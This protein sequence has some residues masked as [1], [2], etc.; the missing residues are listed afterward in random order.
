MSDAVSET[1]GTVD[2]CWEFPTTGHIAWQMRSHWALFGAPNESGISS[3]NH[4][5]EAL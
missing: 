1:D 5:G 3:Y 4:K 2:S